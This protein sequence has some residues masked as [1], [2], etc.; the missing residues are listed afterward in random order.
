[1]KNYFVEQHTSHYDAISRGE[2]T[3]RNISRVTY[4][5]KTPTVLIFQWT[6][7]HRRR[8]S[9]AGPRGTERKRSARFALSDCPLFHEP[10]CAGN[11]TAMCTELLLIKGIVERLVEKPRREPTTQSTKLHLAVWTATRKG[12][13]ALSFP[14][15]SWHGHL[16]L[17]Q[18]RFGGLA[19]RRDTDLTRKA[20]FQF[21][22]WGLATSQGECICMSEMSVLCKDRTIAGLMLENYL[23][24]A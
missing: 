21:H 5:T 12:C 6:V 3:P 22:G 8:D 15:R 4:P 23:Y 11:P 24:L 7:F 9:G 17:T 13:V 18:S 2:W 16:N 10:L 14:R 19:D 20:Q 1:M